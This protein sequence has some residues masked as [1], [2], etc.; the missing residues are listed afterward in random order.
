MRAEK[1]IQLIEW[2]AVG[3]GI[4]LMY[5]FIDRQSL[6]GVLKTILPGKEAGLVE[7]IVLGS[8]EGMSYEYYQKL[9]RSGLVHM[10]VASGANLILISRVVIENLAW[11]LGRKKAIVLGLAGMWGYAWMVGLEP[12]IVRAVIFMTLANMAVLWGRQFDWVRA[13]LV[14]VGMMVAVDWSVVTGLSFWLSL[15]AFVAISLGV[16][17]NFQFKKVKI[18]GKKIFLETV[19]VNLWIWPI[20]AMGVGKIGLAG[21]VTA[22]A[23]TGLVEIITMVGGAG[24]ILG[25]VSIDLARMVLWLMM[26]V[27]RWFDEV[28]EWGSKF[29]LWE[30]EFN[31]LILVG[32]YLILIYIV[33]RK[34]ISFLATNFLFRF[35]QRR[36]G[37]C[38]AVKKIRI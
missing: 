24:L 33:Y 29:G 20:L 27:L 12:P 2:L 7:G 13:I 32:Y 16:P 21:L 30:I 22:V 35:R 5:K 34:R 37:N 15:A 38:F 10:V 31:W 19:W 23:V 18:P 28:V 1:K 11:L 14:T 25:L 3:I 17:E 9:I 4:L 36:T 6:I 8:K 26:P